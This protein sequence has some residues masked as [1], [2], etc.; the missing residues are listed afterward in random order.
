MSVHENENEELQ[1]LLF[2]LAFLNRAFSISGLTLGTR[3]TNVGLLI[4]SY[5]IKARLTCVRW[6]MNGTVNNLLAPLCKNTSA[7]SAL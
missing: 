7:L 4:T 2:F 1:P 3:A 6:A 5:S